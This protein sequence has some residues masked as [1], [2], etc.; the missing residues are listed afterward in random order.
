M[1]G[2]GV[3]RLNAN[4]DTWWLPSKLDAPVVNS[5]RTILVAS[6]IRPTGSSS[7]RPYQ[8][9]TVTA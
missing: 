9:C 1:S 5:C 7:L 4:R 8:P 6:L 2:R 3:Y